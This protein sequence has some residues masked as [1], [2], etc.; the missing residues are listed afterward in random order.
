MSAHTFYPLQ[1]WQH[2]V[3]LQG[4]SAVSALHAP[5]AP[6]GTRFVACF[7]GT[8]NSK[9]GSPVTTDTL[10]EQQTTVERIFDQ[11]LQSRGAAAVYL[12]G[13]GAR[14]LGKDPDC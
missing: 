9:F 12:G 5:P 7:D 11:V 4:L 3:A 10:A 14:M 13:V 2:D 1:D 8:Y 6:S